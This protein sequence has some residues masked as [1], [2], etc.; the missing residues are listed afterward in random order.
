MDLVV[1]SFKRLLE[2]SKVLEDEIVVSRSGYNHALIPSKNAYS[3][4][5]NDL[6]AMSLAC[7]GIE[8]DELLD[9]TIVKKRIKLNLNTNGSNL[10]GIG[11]FLLFFKS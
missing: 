2:Q 9:A 4:S 8:D 10:P 3:D 6:M 5:Q 11:D 1:S 7:S